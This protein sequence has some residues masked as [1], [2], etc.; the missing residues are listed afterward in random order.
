MALRTFLITKNI[1]WYD[2]E[3]TTIEV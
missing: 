2:E 1:P 3:G